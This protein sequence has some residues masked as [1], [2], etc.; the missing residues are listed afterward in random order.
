MELTFERVVL[1]QVVFEVHWEEGA[2][3]VTTE[4]K[5]HLGQV[6]GAYICV[7]SMR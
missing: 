2:H 1:E 6:V 3:I 4:A 7:Y 5:S